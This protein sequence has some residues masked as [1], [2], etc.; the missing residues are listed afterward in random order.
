[1]RQIGATAIAAILIACGGDGFSAL[2][3]EAEENISENLEE[4]SEESSEEKSE[5]EKTEEEN[6]DGEYLDGGIKKQDAEKENPPT[7]ND[8]G[9][10]NDEDGGENSS[11]CIPKTCT[12]IQRELRA[13]YEDEELEICGEH[14]DGCRNWIDCGNECTKPHHICNGIIPVHTGH[15]FYIPETPFISQNNPGIC[16]GG[17]TYISPVTF[18]CDNTTLT[19]GWKEYTYLCTTED[20][21]H[22]AQP[23]DCYSTASSEVTYWCCDKKYSYIGEDMY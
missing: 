19:G 5:K 16:N 22:L 17:C 15:P 18:H 23:G 2:K 4:N 21:P 20:M 1:M 8:G 7:E 13:E 12:T 9:N 10:L 3:N 6:Y 11:E 14:Y